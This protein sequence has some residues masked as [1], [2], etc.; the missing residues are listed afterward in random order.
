MAGQ[1]FQES[2]WPR[3]QEWR[4]GLQ[5]AGFAQ[6]PQGLADAVPITP[7]LIPPRALRH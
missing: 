1:G 4:P 5:G 3:G 6:A 7:A 2:P